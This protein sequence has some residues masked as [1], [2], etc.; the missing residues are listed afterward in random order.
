M[1][2]NTFTTEWKLMFTRPVTR[3]IF[4]ITVLVLV[5]SLNL[6]SKFLVYVEIR[7]GVVLHDPLFDLFDAYDFNTTIFIFIYGSLITGLISL[8]PR[9][10][11]LMLALQTYSIMV[12]FRFIAMYLTPLDV[13][14]GIIN[15]RDPLVFTV[16]TGMVVTKDLFFSGHIAS[17]TILFF[18][19]K[20]KYLRWTFFIVGLFVGSMIFLQKAHYTI[21]ML[22]APF[23]AFAAYTIAKK[24]D[25]KLFKEKIT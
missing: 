6:F 12:I 11:F 24:L 8:L 18:T 3:Y 17:L 10:R 5:I 16:G 22:A 21:D 14:R 2:T 20:N 9:P 19:A 25:S 15:L 13:P 1:S 4:L 7:P 23:F